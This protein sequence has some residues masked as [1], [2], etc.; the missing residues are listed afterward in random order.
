MLADNIE[1]DEVCSLKYV[2]RRI[3]AGYNGIIVR[4]TSYFDTLS[5]KHNFK[6]TFEVE[7]GSENQFPGLF[8]VMQNMHMRRDPKTGDCIDYV[9]VSRAFLNEL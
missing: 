6:C 1:S 4:E 8:V 3:N 9:K 5:G 2:K 7:T